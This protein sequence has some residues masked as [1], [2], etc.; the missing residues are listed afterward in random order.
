[1]ATEK[2]VIKSAM[3]KKA[4]A[5]IDAM[6]HVVVHSRLQCIVAAVNA[7]GLQ[8]SNSGT[9]IIKDSTFTETGGA[10]GGGCA[11]RDRIQIGPLREALHQQLQDTIQARDSL[12]GDATALRARL[13][14]SVTVDVVNSCLATA[15]NVTTIALTGVAGKVEIDNLNVA[16]QAQAYLGQCLS[17][18]RVQ[19]GDVTQSLQQHLEDNASWLRV[20]ALDGT[21]YPEAAGCPSSTQALKAFMSTAATANVVGLT[22]GMLLIVVAVMVV[23]YQSQR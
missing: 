23:R 10:A 13:V 14:E 12:H 8:V 22:A 1:M 17:Q 18:T 21:V 19:I 11:Q 15:T 6:S 2:V 9:V 5:V 16:M 4:N 20:T 3:G 7:F